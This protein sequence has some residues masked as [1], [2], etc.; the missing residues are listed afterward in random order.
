MLATMNN[1]NEFLIWR[2]PSFELRAEDKPLVDRSDGGHIAIYPKKRIPDRQCLT[3]KQATEFMRLTM[4]AGEAMS[5]AMRANGVD[6]GRINYQDNGNWSVFTPAGPYFHL[7]VYGRAISAKIQ[8][9]GQSLNF[10]HREE[11]P[12]FYRNNE[13]LSSKDIEAIRIQMNLLMKSEK[14][15]DAGW[16]T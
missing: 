5:T 3:R 7:H 13:P 16:D 6:I 9:Y 2:T 4:V 15:A 14:Y 8:K 1:Q 10:P 12:D 11:Y